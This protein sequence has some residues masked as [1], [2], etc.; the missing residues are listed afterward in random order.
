M[1]IHDIIDQRCLPVFIF[2]FVFTFLFAFCV[3]VRFFDSN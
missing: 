3:Y 2:Y 1:Q